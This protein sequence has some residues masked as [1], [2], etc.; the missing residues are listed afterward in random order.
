LKGL[1]KRAITAV[2]FILI[3][4]AGIF[5]G[6]YA[7]ISLFS[8]ITGLCLWEFLGMTLE[9]E[10][11]LTAFLRRISGI[12][13]GLVP[14]ELVFLLMRYEGFE[15]ITTMFVAVFIPLV[16]LMFIF[17]MFSKTRKPFANLAF[18]LMG[19]V[20]IGVPF[21][22]LSYITLYRGFYD[23]NIVFGLL[24]LVWMNDTGAYLGGSK[25]G[26]TKL[27]PRISPKKTW[28]GFFFG[29]IATLITAYAVCN[30]LP[31]PLDLMNWI[32]LAI[33][34]ILFGTT[35]DLV[36]SMLKRSVQV[37]DS[38]R[39]LPGHG[40]VLDR[41]DAFIFILPFTTAY[42]LLIQ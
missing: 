37:K 2:F 36:E 20:Y 34:V 32:A 22:M 7:F 1:S 30:L 24:A 12:I 29:I 11:Y 14:L 33:I 15:R 8:I 19:V 18:I 35:G 28:E 38:G 41:F 13:L 4:L 26:K 21:A 40:G 5:G 27:L 9:D 6:P 31:G 10:N 25:F 42:L 17:E 16:F 23:P 39:L 3:M